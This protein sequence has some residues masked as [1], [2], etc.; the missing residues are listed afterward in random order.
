MWVNKV[1]KTSSTSFE[2][3][4]KSVQLCF[5]MKWKDIG[6]CRHLDIFL[7][8]SYDN[9]INWWNYRY[10]SFVPPDAPRSMF[11]RSGRL[12]RLMRDNLSFWRD[13]FFVCILWVFQWIQKKEW[14]GWY[15]L[16]VLFKVKVILTFNKSVNYYSL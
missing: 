3:R 9:I 14:M 5:I 2:E 13:I 16:Y 4:V 8:I 11:G 1:F 15:F 12:K 7:K 10:H 6:Y